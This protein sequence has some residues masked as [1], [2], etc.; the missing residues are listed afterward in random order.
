MDMSLKPAK[1]GL[2]IMRVGLVEVDT[3]H[4]DN[5]LP[6]LSEDVMEQW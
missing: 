3:P 4:R 5:E 2:H 6:R 1:D